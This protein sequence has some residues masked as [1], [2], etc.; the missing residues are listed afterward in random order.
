MHAAFDSRIVR[1]ALAATCALVVAA[2]AGGAAAQ[3]KPAPQRSG[4]DVALANPATRFVP[5]QVLVRFRQGVSAQEREA[6]L[7]EQ[8][9]GDPGAWGGRA[10]DRS[11]IRRGSDRPVRLGC[12]SG[13]ILSGHLPSDPVSR[14]LRL[15]SLVIRFQGWS[16][17]GIQGMVAGAGTRPGPARRARWARSWTGS[18]G[19]GSVASSRS[20]SKATTEP[21]RRAS[22]LPVQTQMP[23]SAA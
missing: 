1:L 14:C 5:G 18:A 22:P 2:L 7:A 4:K 9:A 20:P 17:G 12:R 16:A 6:A 11:V 23:P 13:V 19:A 8:S 15:G 21:S 10:R 3:S